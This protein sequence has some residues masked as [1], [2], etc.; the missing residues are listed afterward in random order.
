MEL[1]EIFHSDLAETATFGATAY[2]CVS[3][4]TSAQY[5]EY[6]EVLRPQV[7][8]SLRLAIA[9]FATLPAEGDKVTFRQATYRVLS[10]PRPD[11]FNITFILLLGDEYAR[12]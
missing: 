3:G 5:N 2:R 8:L 1:N 6:D 7:R 12:R 10:R 4:P 9:D 11:S